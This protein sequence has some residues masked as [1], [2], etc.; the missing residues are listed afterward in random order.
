M[1]IVVTVKA[2]HLYSKQTHAQKTDNAKE[3]QRDL[4]R[5]RVISIEL[6]RL[7]VLKVAKNSF[8]VSWSTET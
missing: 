5:S 2:T 4:R 6:L 1:P 7:W 3:T 8:I